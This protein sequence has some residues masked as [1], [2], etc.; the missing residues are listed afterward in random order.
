MESKR[1]ELLLS[2]RGSREGGNKEYNKQEKK[3]LY[4]NRIK[5]NELY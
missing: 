5:T 4:P 1:R 3:Y 2:D